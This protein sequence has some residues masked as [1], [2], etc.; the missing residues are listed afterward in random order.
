VNNVFIGTSN[1][2]GAFESGVATRLVGPVAAVV[3]GGVA[4]ILVVLGVMKKWPSIRELDTLEGAAARHHQTNNGAG[5]VADSIEKPENS[6]PTA[7][8]DNIKKS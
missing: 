6:I 1:E 8:A 5:S 3:G 4:T 7:G 2:L